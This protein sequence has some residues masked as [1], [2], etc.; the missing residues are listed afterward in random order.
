MFLI[1]TLSLAIQD[2]ATD[3]GTTT[4]TARKI[5][6]AIEDVPASVAIVEVT[7]DEFC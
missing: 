6:E 4:V 7:V 3:L 5:E 1:L 2:P